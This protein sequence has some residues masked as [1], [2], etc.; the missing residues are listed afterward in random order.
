M[1]LSR[2]VDIPL[3]FLMYFTICLICKPW[4]LQCNSKSGEQLKYAWIVS[5]NIVYYFFIKLCSIQN[6]LI[7]LVLLD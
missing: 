4:M 6:T 3:I 2:N 5:M 1:E 7:R